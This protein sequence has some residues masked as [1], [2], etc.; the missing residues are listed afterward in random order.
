MYIRTYM[1]LYIHTD[2]A[3]ALHPQRTL[4]RRIAEMEEGPADRILPA[5]WVRIER[6]RA[7]MWVC[8]CV[9]MCMGVCVCVRVCVCAMIK[10][11]QWLIVSC[12]QDW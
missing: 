3:M 6:Q 1:Y 9:G 7:R 11:K 2:K 12:Q 4:A 10:K 5:G 8:G